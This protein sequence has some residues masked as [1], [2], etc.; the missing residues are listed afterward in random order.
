MFCV[1]E[2]SLSLKD[3]FE[4]ESSKLLEFDEIEPLQALS[5]TNW[6][7]YPNSRIC[8]LGKEDSFSIFM[9][10]HE[11]WHSCFSSV[12]AI[13]AWVQWHQIF[14]WILNYSWI[15]F[16]RRVKASN[17]QCLEQNSVSSF[18]STQQHISKIE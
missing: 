12:C 10:K 5:N 4:L 3:R 14:A 6:Q 16:L 9:A 17:Q 11:N 1:F 2:I 18:K 8:Y 13:L 7:A 15:T